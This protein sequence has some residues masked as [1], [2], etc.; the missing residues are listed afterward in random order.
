M[1]ESFCRC[2]AVAIPKSPRSF[3]CPH[4]PPAPLCACLLPSCKA[5]CR[6]FSSAMGAA[7]PW[8]GCWPTTAPA[9]SV[10]APIAM[11]C[12]ACPVMSRPWPAAGS[13]AR[14]RH[15]SA[16]WPPAMC[17]SMLRAVLP[18]QHWRRPVSCW[19]RRRATQAL[20]CWRSTTR[21]TSPRYGRM[22]S[23]SPKRAW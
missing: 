6:P 23:R 18:S 9:P 21:T 1:K 16:T 15:R 4:L 14:P 22:S 12:S 20:P 10:M 13:M 7:R 5:C 19:W 3:R 2:N 17:V 8:P 11:G